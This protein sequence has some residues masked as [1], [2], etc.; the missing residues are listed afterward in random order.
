MIYLDYAANTPVDEEVISAFVEATRKYIANPN[1][2]HPLGIEAK[3]RVDEVSNM[4]ADYFK[5][6]YISY[7]YSR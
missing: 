3:E 2:L 7:R 1:S 6:S 4:L 5:C